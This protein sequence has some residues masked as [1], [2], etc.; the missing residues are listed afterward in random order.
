MSPQ[1][2][3]FCTLGSGSSGNA[4]YVGTA[5]G[6]VLV[7]AGI[8]GRQIARRLEARGLPPESLQ[9]I[10]VTHDHSDH[11]RAAGTLARRHHLP[12]YMTH[13]AAR[14]ATARIGRVPGLHCF[15][16]G[17]AM[18]LAGC[19]IRTVPT[20]H[21]APDPVALVF[22][23]GPVRVGHFTDLGHCF[24]GM[25][26]LLA[27]LDA[28]IL[29]SNYDPEM[30]AANPRYPEHLKARIR[31][32]HGHLANEEAAALLRDHAGE[33]LRAV[34]LAHLSDKN[35]R[36][37][38]ALACHRRVAADFLAARRPLLEAAPRHTPSRLFV[39]GPP[40]EPS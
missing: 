28:V 7:D 1:T 34:L 29:E 33:R 37:D 8:S 18:R 19:R 35:N 13:G 31:G 30:L 5:E 24:A 6:G 23:R 12:L 17:E 38:L 21:D 25:G 36:P 14:R 11:L 9:A 16:P 3:R 20:P 27:E 26:A 4:L 40:Q 2:I 22:E 32:P 39:I 10:L 15:A